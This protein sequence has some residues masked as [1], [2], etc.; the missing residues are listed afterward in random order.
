MIWERF[1]GARR[2]VSWSELQDL[3]NQAANVLRDH[4]VERGERVAVLLPP[5]PE[6][7]QAGA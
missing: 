7:A 5:T 1:D 2:D 6:A 3:S 4:G